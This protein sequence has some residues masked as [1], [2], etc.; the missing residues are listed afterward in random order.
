M[1]LA[2]DDTWLP[3]YHVTADRNWL[4]DPNGPIHVD[5]RYHLFF[6]ANPAAPEW[7]PPHWGHVSSTDLVTWT[8]HP[9]ALAPGPDPDAPDR[10]GC[11]S[12]C[13]RIVDGRPTIYYTGV[14][15]DGDERVESICRAV[16]SADLKEWTK[17]PDNPLVAGPPAPLGSGYHRDPFLWRDDDGWHLL[18]GS[19]TIGPDRHG[20]VLVYHSPDARSWT[21]GGVFFEAPRHLDGTDLGEHWECPQLLRFDDGD[22]LVLSAQDPHA[23]HPLMHAVYFVGKAAEGRFDGQLG[24][25][26]DGGDAWYAPAATVDAGG[27]TLIW[28]WIQEHL[29]P[30]TQRRLPRVG[31]LSLPRVATLTDGALTTVPAPE[32][33]RLRTGP[34]L[35]GPVT[36]HGHSHLLPAHDHGQLEVTA[37][38][39]GE[40]GTARWELGPGLAVAVDL[41][42]HRFTLTTPHG[43]HHAGIG[44][45]PL[46]EAELRIFLDGTICEVH[47]ADQ[48]SL[49]AR[50]YPPSAG[51]GP[52]TA[53]AGPAVEAAACTVWRLA[54]A[55][56]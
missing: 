13:A 15:G 51:R 14:V 39:S 26:L 18:L 42:R 1:S 9:V 2:P 20:T 44:H 12:G 37:R 5:G 52:I 41:D 29:P 47:L 10:D 19:G 22:V 56:P 55:L 27:R 50:C 33:D 21:Y 54:G 34:P 11:W 7:G 53:L 45:R 24:G 23:P 48:A 43:H 38:I 17:D 3:R 36:V 25:R 8:R 46:T 28:G 4:N 32:L 6:Q 16:G 49:T 35:A 31:A 30:E 40:A